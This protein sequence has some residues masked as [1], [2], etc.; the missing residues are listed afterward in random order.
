MAEGAS[1]DSKTFDTRDVAQQN[2]GGASQS[3]AQKDST[4]F[5]HESVGKALKTK[6]SD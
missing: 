5:T 3:G 1:K 6:Y 2:L 4:P